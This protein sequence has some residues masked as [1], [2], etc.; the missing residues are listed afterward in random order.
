MPEKYQGHSSEQHL[1]LPLV[2]RALILRSGS[3]KLCLHPSTRGRPSHFSQAKKKYRGS[4][5]DTRVKVLPPGAEVA[6][7]PNAAA[8]I[9]Y[10]RLGIL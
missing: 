6:A 7:F 5:G 9:K 1:Q 2:G 8:I 10:R 3:W 4:Q